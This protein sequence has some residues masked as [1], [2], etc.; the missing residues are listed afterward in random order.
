M[1]IERKDLRCM[2]IGKEREGVGVSSGCGADVLGGSLPGGG[3]CSGHH[4]AAAH[5]LRPAGS[6]G[7]GHQL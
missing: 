7:G 4:P 6:E 5:L 2:G 3:E 1:R